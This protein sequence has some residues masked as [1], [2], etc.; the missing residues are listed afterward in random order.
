MGVREGFTEEITFELE[1]EGLAGEKWQGMSSRVPMSKRRK[2][3]K[4]TTCPAALSRR[5]AAA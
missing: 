3:Q 2:A 5:V 4:S 1:F